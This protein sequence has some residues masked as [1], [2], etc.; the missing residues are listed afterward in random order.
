M[1]ETV[2]K[3]KDIV[4]NINHGVS[5]YDIKFVQQI[6]K[7]IDDALSPL[8]FSRSETTKADMGCSLI[9]FQFGVGL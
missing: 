8:G 3:Q 2:G 6:E 1:T 5:E 9:Y 4:V 7:A